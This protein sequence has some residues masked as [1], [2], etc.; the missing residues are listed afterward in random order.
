MWPDFLRSSMSTSTCWAGIPSRC[1]KRWRGANC[2]PCAIRRLT[3]NSLHS[4]ARGDEDGLTGLFVPLFPKPQIRQ[5]TGW[6]FPTAQD[7]EDLE[8]WLR[9]Q[10]AKEA[11]T[12]DTCLIPRANEMARPLRAAV[13]ETA[14]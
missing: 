7:E 11:H 9:I 2:G 14:S 3:R 10:G 8:N 13:S 12:A 5:H 1:R 4:V 6:R